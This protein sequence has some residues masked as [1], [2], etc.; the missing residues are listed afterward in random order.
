MIY[1][2]V[3]KIR[4]IPKYVSAQS[5]P[6]G[7][8]KTNRRLAGFCHN[9]SSFMNSNF[10]KM[11]SSQGQITKNVRNES[12]SIPEKLLNEICH[13]VVEIETETIYFIANAHTKW[14][15]VLQRSKISTLRC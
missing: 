11:S 1:L 5:F 14:C 9:N 4:D 8:W 6:H 15:V 3:Y 12:I 10:T 7:L 2:F 13:D